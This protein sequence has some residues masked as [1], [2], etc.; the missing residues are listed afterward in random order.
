MLKTGQAMTL[1]REEGDYYLVSLTNGRRGYVLKS[2]L[3]DEAPAEHHLQ[4]VQENAQKQVKM[5]EEHV[6][7][8]AEELEQ[9]RQ[10]NARL[11]EMASAQAERESAAQAELQQLQAERGHLS[12]FL[13]GAGV[14]FLGWLLG[15]TRVGLW[16]KT[17]RQGLT[18]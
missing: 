8:Q 17:R 1:I 3:T 14:L 10:E 18:F 13:A 4:A 5:L 7:R 16:R 11:A 2:Y 12:W 6:Q 9:L 15:W